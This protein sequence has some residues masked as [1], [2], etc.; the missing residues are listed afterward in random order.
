V[1]GGDGAGGGVGAGE[2]WWHEGRGIGEGAHSLI[3][4][5]EAEVTALHRLF[6]TGTT[7]GNL[8]TREKSDTSEAYA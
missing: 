1:G 4:L 6:S 8:I 3:S 7:N 5:H 2:G